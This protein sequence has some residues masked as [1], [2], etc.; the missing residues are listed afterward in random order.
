MELYYEKAEYVVDDTLA[1]RTWWIDEEY[2]FFE[3]YGDVTVNLSEYGMKPEEGHIFIP[4]YKMTPDYYG[5]IVHDIIEEVIAP[6]Q[7]GLGVGVYAKL[8]EN[9]EDGVKMMKGEM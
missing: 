8:K 5:Q 6:V 1:I 4:T 9:W 3:P 2:G 7:I